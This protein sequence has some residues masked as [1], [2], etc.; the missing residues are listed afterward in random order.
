MSD[1]KWT[2]TP[3]LRW[4]IFVSMGSPVLQQASV[5]SEGNKRWDEVPMTYHPGWNDPA[6]EHGPG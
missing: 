4:R 6:R 3:E 5:D 1:N 2:L